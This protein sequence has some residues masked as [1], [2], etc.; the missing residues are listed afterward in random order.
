MKELPTGSR[1]T[2][3][4]VEG[5]CKKCFFYKNHSCLLD[6]DG[7][8]YEHIRKDKKAIIYKEVKE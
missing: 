6:G 1:I 4:V 2:L 5:K 7:N 3:E 8:C